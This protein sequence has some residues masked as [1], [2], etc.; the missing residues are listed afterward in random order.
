MALVRGGY[1]IGNYDE[2]MAH[3]GKS[4]TRYDRPHHSD[5]TICNEIGLS[6]AWRDVAR[7]WHGAKLA[8]EGLVDGALSS[9]D[10]DMTWMM[11]KETTERENRFW[12]FLSGTKL[13][14]FGVFKRRFKPPERPPR[15]IRTRRTR[16]AR[17]RSSPAPTAL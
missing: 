13:L 7:M 4:M 16:C 12:R 15:A 2:R 11:Q 8:L 9:K 1:K 3:N 17:S 5:I 14:H 10:V 6:V